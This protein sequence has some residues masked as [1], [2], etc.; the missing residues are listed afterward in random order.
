L[1]NGGIFIF[2]FYTKRKLQYWNEVSY[3]ENEKLDY[4]RNVVSD[5][6]SKTSISNIYYI[7]INPKELDDLKE[8]EYSF[9]NYENKYKRTE[10]VTVEYYFENND[11]INAIK[12]SGYRYLIT[13][14]QNFRPVSS[15]SDMN[16]IHVIAIKR[17]K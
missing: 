7:N 12:R 15:I 13:T 10:D 3:D 11:I 8:K 1:N 9:N 16:R 5:G 6:V 17:E 2:D 14:D 4:V